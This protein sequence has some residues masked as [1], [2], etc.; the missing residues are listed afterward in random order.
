MKPH[1]TW[2]TA[3]RALTKRWWFLLLCAIAAAVAAAGAAHRQRPTFVV[4]T[5]IND[6]PGLKLG[7]EPGAGTVPTLYVEN[8]N[9]KSGWKVVNWQN[10]AIADKAAKELQSQVD[11]TAFVNGLRLPA[12]AQQNPKV[13]TPSSR[14]ATSGKVK[15]ST[16]TFTYQTSSKPQQTAVLMRRYF[17]DFLAARKSAIVSKIPSTLQTMKK[18]RDA[19]GHPPSDSSLGHEKTNL[20][21]AITALGTWTTNDPLDQMLQV[22]GKTTFVKTKSPLRTPLAAAGGAIIGLLAGALI[23]LAIRWGRGRITDESELVP[24]EK[25][26]ITVDSRTGDGFEMLRAELEATGIGAESAVVAVATAQN[27]D[28]RSDLALE[29]ARSFARA[30]I[31]TAFVSANPL[32]PGEMA[33]N[34]TAAFLSGNEAVLETIPVQPDLVWVPFG[35]EPDEGVTVTADNAQAL[36][37]AVRLFARAII[38]EIAPVESDPSARLFAHSADALVLQVNRH[39]S[40]GARIYNAAL[41]LHR[42]THAP[43]VVGFEVGPVRRKGTATEPERIMTP[44]TRVTAGAP[45]GS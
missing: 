13:L 44:P 30:G 2:K 42:A 41:T 14:F 21:E 31:S 10:Q 28:G 7:I 39:R 5:T 25:P 29:L 19:L 26:I 15:P 16:L 3:R 12:D 22:V 8:P 33:G 35:D 27:G 45:T 40:R 11:A 9:G 23:L 4:S 38:I 20:K 32:A 18:S 17:S 36:V 34:G 37:S 24:L 6:V 43:L 1:M